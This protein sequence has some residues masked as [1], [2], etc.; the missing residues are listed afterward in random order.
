VHRSWPAAGRR[1]DLLAEPVPFGRVQ[2]DRNDLVAALTQI[3]GDAQ[4]R[5][6]VCEEGDGGD[7]PL[8]PRLGQMVDR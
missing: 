8:C 2:V 4:P 3:L 1:D 7:G 6:V 5:Q